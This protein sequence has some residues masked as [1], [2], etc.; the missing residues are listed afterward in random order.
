MWCMLKAAGVGISASLRK[1]ELEP[2]WFKVVKNLHLQRLTL[3][4]KAAG[5]GTGESWAQRHGLTWLVFNC[6]CLKA[7]KKGPLRRRR[8]KKKK[9]ELLR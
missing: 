1:R 7:W 4:G 2:K 6:P 8:E 9:K 5:K 3:L